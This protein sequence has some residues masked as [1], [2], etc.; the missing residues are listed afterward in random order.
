MYLVLPD[1]QLRQTLD[2]TLGWVDQAS[3]G[4]GARYG[5]TTRAQRIGCI[6]IVALVAVALLVYPTATAAVVAGLFSVLY[7]ATVTHRVL[8]VR[9]AVRG[10]RELRVSDEDA[11][12]IADE[13]LPTYTVLVPAFGEPEVV[14]GMLSALEEIEYPRHLFEVRLLLEE[15]DPATLEA[16]KSA[17][18]SLPLTVLVVPAGSPQTKPRALNYGLA[19]SSGELVTVYDAEDH[20]DTLQLRRAAV[21]FRRLGPQWACLQGKLNFYGSRRNLLTRWFSVEYST[22]FSLYLPGLAA[23]GGIV[24]LG[25]TSNHFRRGPLREVGAW[26]P[27]N[28]TEDADLGIR[29]QR[30]GYR[31]GVLDS[32]TLE[33]PNGDLVNW[34]KQRSRWHK[35]YLLTAIV[36]LRRPRALVA[37]LGVRG[38]V[39]LVL[40]IL[41]TP[42]LAVANLAF[43]LLALIWVIAQPSFILDIFP[44][45][46][47]HLA[48]V[49]WVLGNFLII[50]LNVATLYVVGQDDFLV[51]ALLSPL[52]WVVMSVAAV[53]AALQLVTDPHYWEKTVHG[54]ASPPSDGVAQDLDVPA[55][56]DPQGS[57]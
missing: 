41:G 48:A 3:P 31:I 45:L 32:T 2:D 42:F 15:S 11:R 36:H 39:D 23:G 18:T 51:A 5:T 49:S 19:L 37:E 21:A 10:G 6:V 26:D 17:E 47:F 28:V 33:E 38:L 29:L 34:V 54:L 40:F 44:G 1:E 43:W 14:A 50:Y 8:I 35:G 25:G 27:F 12:A 9:R 7:L 52:Y 20:P 55:G 30:R 46:M 53:R 24:P 22:W 16:V 56:V 13:L 4:M 57:G